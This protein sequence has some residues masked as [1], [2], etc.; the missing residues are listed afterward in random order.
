MNEKDAL[1]NV[2]ANNARIYS[3]MFDVYEKVRNAKESID[4]L[5]ACGADYYKGYKIVG[6]VSFEHF[7]EAEHDGDEDEYFYAAS[8]WQ[9]TSEH[10]KIPKYVSDI[11]RI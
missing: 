10:G 9:V 2:Q 6:G 8:K 1:G 3:L 11:Q 5:I 4:A 7:V